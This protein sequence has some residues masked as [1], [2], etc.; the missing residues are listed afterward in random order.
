[1]KPTTY[2]ALLLIVVGALAAWRK[3]A[4]RPTPDANAPDASTRAI[5][6]NIREILAGHP[7][8]GRQLAAFYLA[9]A[10]VIQRDAGQVIK[11]MAD[12]REVNRRAGLLMFQRTGL[13][14]KY[15]GLGA[16]IE[17]ALSQ[18]IGMDNVPV[19]DANRGAVTAAFR[20]IAWAC[21]DE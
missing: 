11:D 8:D 5:V 15:P 17:A 9:L 12:V 21:G 20:A 14:G 13:Q 10:D 4:D 1:V 19:D 3:P 18:L 16:A 2:V 6:A 7:E